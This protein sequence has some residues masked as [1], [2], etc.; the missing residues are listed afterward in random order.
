[1]IIRRYLLNLMLLSR[2]STRKDSALTFHKRCLSS[3]A[4]QKIAYHTSRVAT[5]E[6]IKDAEET[7]AARSARGADDPIDDIGI[8]NT[9][10]TV[11]LVKHKH[12]KDIVLPS[13]PPLP[14]TVS[15]ET[16]SLIEQ[17]LTLCCTMCDFTDNDVDKQAKSI[18]ANALKELANIFCSPTNIKDL[19]PEMID[20]FFDMIMTNAFRGRPPIPR[21]YLY[22]NDEP[23]MTDNAWPHLAL[24]YRLLNGYRDIQPKDARF[25]DWSWLRQWTPLFAAADMK[26]RDEVLKFCSGCIQNFPE[27]ET[28]FFDELAFLLVEYREGRSDPFCVTPSLKYLF[29][30]MKANEA[31]MKYYTD[32]VTRFVVPLVACPHVSSFYWILTQIFD[33]VIEADENMAPVY[34]RGVLRCWPESKPSKQILFINL[35]NFLVQRLNPSVFEEETRP[36]FHLY[37]RCAMSCHAK[38]ADASFQIWQNV[39]IIPM[40]IDNSKAIFPIVFN[41]LHRAMKDHW[42]TRVQNNALNCLKSLHELDPFMFDE[43]TQAQKKGQMAGPD[44]AGV[45]LHKNWAT[46][47]RA[48]ARVDREFNLAKILAD[49]QIRFNATTVAASTS[50]RKPT[51]PRAI[52]SSSPQ[53]GMSLP[54]LGR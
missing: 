17:K 50:Q 54:R 10:M 37:A 24:V 14:V 1:M 34:L 46:V 25:G 41:V 30:R 8:P 49:I 20:K 23:I 11:E 6:P 29:E 28:R 32:F 35:I 5:L 12:H 18:K 52:N 31:K 13:L 3:S 21:K 47:A 48:A 39:N 53:P 15:P 36:V 7:K 44:P 26:E 2:Y 27:H 38:V 9:L 42:N 40:I 45:Q 19:S 22:W 33:A 16:I 43:L 4:L 51:L